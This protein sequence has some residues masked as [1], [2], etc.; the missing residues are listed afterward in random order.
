M[1]GAETVYRGN[2]VNFTIQLTNMY[3]TNRN[4]FKSLFI[5]NHNINDLG[6]DQVIVNILYNLIMKQMIVLNKPFSMSILPNYYNIIAK[7][8]VFMLDCNY[9]FQTLN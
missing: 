2:C 8:F 4:H 6:L 7:C 9:M 3:N 5:Y 1:M